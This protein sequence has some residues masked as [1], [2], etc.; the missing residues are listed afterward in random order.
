MM[1]RSDRARRIVLGGALALPMLLAGCIQGQGPV[2]T[3]SREIRPFTRL[4][5][6]SGIQVALAIGPA[7][8]VIV[9]A[10][11]NVLRA[12]ATTVEGATLKVTATDDFTV[13]EPVTVTVTVPSLEGVSTSGGA[14]ATIRG[15][16]ATR[17]GLEV[18]GGS[19][20]VIAGSAGA[21][22]LRADGGSAVDLGG[23]TAG[24]VELDIAGGTTATV[25]ATDT[26][27]G[28]ASGGAHL[29]VLGDPV[30]D[31][32]AT[33]GAEVTRAPEA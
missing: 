24:T 29:A 15:V 10:Q 18:M 22:A 4:E 1:T 17:L 30:V 12:V 28:F 23:L 7:G 14:H 16:E 33:G 26:V 27:R 8:P 6:G 9:S 13:S 19:Q 31:V 5:V 25:K 20:V 11:A 21:I 2:T 32:R 3:E